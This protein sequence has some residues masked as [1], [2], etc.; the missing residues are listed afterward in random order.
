MSKESNRPKHSRVLI[1]AV[2]L[3]VL[4]TALILLEHSRNA[5]KS[6]PDYQR[7]TVWH[8]GVAYYPRQ[9]VDLFLIMGIDR[10]GRVESSGTYN[11]DGSADAIMLVILNESA[12]TFD[13]LALNRDSMVDMPVLG[14]HGKPAGTVNA[15]LALSHTYGNGLHTSCENTVETVSDLLC[16]IQ[17]DYY[18]S[19]NMD[20]VVDLNDAVGGVRVNVTDDFSKVDSTIHKGE[21]V[22]KGQQALHYVQMRQ[23]VEDGLNISRMRRQQEYLQGFFEAYKASD[24]HGITETLELFSSVEP[25]IVTNCT[26]TVMA[27]LLDDFK[28]YRF[29]E[30]YTPAGEN[31]IGETYME[32]HLDKDALLELTLQ[33]LYEPK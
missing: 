9:D 15:Q 29:G 1:I 28:D 13:I 27:S 24:K 26:D 32:F 14:L 16:G 17:I 12:K 6:D 4:V 19:M 30:I 22:L 25:Y 20:A 3:C 11:N 5:G 7:K 23:D 2:I 18:L 21:I 31:I 8:N 10:H 33:L